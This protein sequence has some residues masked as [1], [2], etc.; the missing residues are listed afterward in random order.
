MGLVQKIDV[1][2]E[3]PASAMALRT[4]LRAEIHRLATEGQNPIIAAAS[5]RAGGG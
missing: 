1:F 3:S 4:L 5:S 2:Y